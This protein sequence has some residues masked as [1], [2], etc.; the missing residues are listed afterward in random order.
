MNFERLS[1]QSLGRKHSFTASLYSSGSIRHITRRS[2]NLGNME[3]EGVGGGVPPTPGSF[4]VFRVQ[5]KR[6]GAYFG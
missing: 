2:S 5:N 6:S 1:I 4:C 3:G